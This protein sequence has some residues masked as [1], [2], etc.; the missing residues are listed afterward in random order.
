MWIAVLCSVKLFP[1]LEA[2]LKGVFN[3]VL[4][5]LDLFNNSIGPEGAIAIAEALKVTAVLTTL[6]L[7]GNSIGDEG[8]NAIAEALKVTAVL[9]TPFKVASKIGNN[10]TEH[11][12]AIPTCSQCSHTHFLQL[13]HKSTPVLHRVSHRFFPCIF[14]AVE[15][16]VEL[17]QHRVDLQRLRD[18]LGTVV[19][20]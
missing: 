17:G 8:A 20:D 13:Q 5:K 10:F 4:T 12:T 3:R 14:H 9:K 19:A 7:G 6:R 2:A 16:E 15:L 11:K 1:N 18:R